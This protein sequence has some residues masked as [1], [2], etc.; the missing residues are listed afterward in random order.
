[1]SQEGCGAHR[2]W[3]FSPAL[4]LFAEAPPSADD[5]PLK[6]LCIAPGDVRHVLQSIAKE[7]RRAHDTG[8]PARAA[9]FSVYEREP[10]V[11]ARHMLLLAIALDF[12]LPR[13]ERAE[14]LLEVWANIQVREKTA[15]YI[16]QRSLAL[17]KVLTDGE[18]P[19]AA[20]FD[21]SALK[22][23]DCDALLDVLRSWDEAVEFDIVRLHDE[24]LR[25]LYKER[26]D[27]RRNVLDW[28][29]TMELME[30][31]EQGAPCSIVHKIHWR[32]WRMTGLC[33]EVRDSAYV[34]PNRT[35]ASYA[36]GREQGL[37]KMRRGFWGD[38]ACGPWAATGVK[39]EDDRLTQKKNGQH[40]KSSC[41]IGYHNALS[42]LCALESGMGFELKAEDI[43]AFEYG[44]SVAVGGLS[45][46]FL[47]SKSKT[48]PTI[49]E[50]VDEEPAVL[51]EVDEAAEA[52]A[53]AAAAK[54]KDAAASEARRA[55]ETRAKVVTAKMA[56][57]PPFKLRLIAG[58]FV[59]CQRKPRHKG[60]FDVMTISTNLAFVMG[61]SRLNTLLKP[62]ARIHLESAKY[63]IEAGK[64]NR[65]AYGQKQLLVALRLGWTLADAEKH[66]G[67]QHASFEF[68][69]DEAAA[70]ALA[71]KAIAA[72]TAAAEAAGETAP[73]TETAEKD[74][75][76]LLPP[77][78]AE[79][80][81]KAEERVA[82]ADVASLQIVDK[83]SEGGG[84]AAAALPTP[85]PLASVATKAGEAADLSV[86]G[87]G[88]AEK[89]GKLC[90][91]TGLPA[92]YRDP[93][94]G[95]PY[96]N[97]DAFKELRK[98]YPDPKTEPRDAEEAAWKAAAEAA[99]AAA[100]A[101]AEAKAAK[102]AAKAAAIA[103]GEVVE[104][105]DEDDEPAVIRP[106]ARG[107]ITFGSDFM[108]KVNKAF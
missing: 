21:A 6:A 71:E 29:Y 102:A 43:E 74:L 65:V 39:C 70:P 89:N 46:G 36:L 33:F 53:A 61:S 57:L 34:A 58:D 59:D 47:S 44:G 101:A 105:D 79:E 23:R 73:S 31:E 27:H 60:A 62:S 16:A 103:A 37:S 49:V 88:A 8:K 14:L 63:L 85:P 11:L 92:K 19:L 77:T 45:K 95:L 12:E 72:Q 87:A 81:Q 107:E 93:I 26:Y 38:V 98:Q 64:K 68:V 100:A 1:M 52:E 35:M 76:Q 18:G 7:A 51:V 78:E 17:Q 80:E 24:R 82:P 2:F 84:A 99:A 50:E 75:P 4:D 86:G 20:V 10:E 56:K 15:A 96:A 13:R 83:P 28:D 97:L 5:S 48:V 30:M 91:I 22:S 90:A 55:E 40:F 66:D 32:E 104:E 41:D 94:S 9:E 69:Y 108:R 25:A 106:K 42:W 3:G 54:A 67:V